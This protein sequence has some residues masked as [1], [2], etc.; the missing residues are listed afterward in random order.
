MRQFQSTLA[1][2]FCMAFCA[3]QAV[4]AYQQG[5]PV[6]NQVII[7]EDQGLIEIQGQNLLPKNEKDRGVFLASESNVLVE[8]QIQF[9]DDEL[10]QLYLDPLPPT[11]Q[12]RLLVGSPDWKGAAQT[13]IALG[14]FEGPQ[15]PAGEPGPQGPQGE[16][17]PAGPVGEQGPVGPVGDIGPI[18]PT[19]PVGPMGPQGFTGPP[20][21]TGEPGPEGAQGP[22]GPRG[23]TGPQGPAGVS[24][25]QRVT[26]NVSMPTPTSTAGT[27]FGFWRLTCPSGKKGLSGYVR[28]SGTTTANVERIRVWPTSGLFSLDYWDFR[29]ELKRGPLQGPFEGTLIL[30]CAD[31]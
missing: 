6:I 31:V 21:Q 22:T 8:P 19:G 9:Q 15:G 25:Y 28:E 7:I 12:Y 26:L 16:T 4:Q 30:I 14:A 5:D 20:G 23:A 1:I 17:G 18:G 11:G 24:G 10:I 3:P 2:I 29:V 27:E 13:L